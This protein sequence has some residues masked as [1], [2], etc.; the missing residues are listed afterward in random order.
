MDESA[1]KVYVG[2]HAGGMMILNRRTGKKSF[3]INRIV[4][5]QVIIFIQLY[6]M[7]E[8]GCG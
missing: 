1:D 5:Y 2:A 7:R 6:R 8:R 4:T 3:I